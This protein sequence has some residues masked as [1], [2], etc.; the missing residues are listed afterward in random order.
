MVV[1]VIYQSRGGRTKKVADAIAEEC[2]VMASNITEPTALADTDLLFVGMG[3]YS[4]KPDQYLLDYL[5]QLPMNSIRGAAV[6]STSGTGNDRME[7][8]ISMLQHKGI[9]VYPIHCCIRGKG[10]FFGRKRP[11]ESDIKKARAFARQVLSAFQY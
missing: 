1:K 10:L 11:N 6:F 5:D 3:I 2:G 7:L 4:G 9:T 8:A